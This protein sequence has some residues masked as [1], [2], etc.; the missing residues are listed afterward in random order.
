MTIFLVNSLRNSALGMALILLPISVHSQGIISE[1][2]AVSRYAQT[3]TSK[4]PPKTRSKQ[5]T[6]G[7]TSQRKPGVTEISSSQEVTFAQSENKAVFVGDVVVRDPQFVL[8]CQKLTA[9]LRGSE[10][11]EES[12]AGKGGGGL[13]RA[14][15]EGN[16][17]I[18]QDKVDADGKTTRYEGRGQRVVYETATDEVT[19]SGSPSVREGINLHI[20]TDPSTVMKITT[21]EM[22]TSGPSKTIIAPSKDD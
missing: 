4:V 8:T 16:V 19:L 9:Y 12:Q 10:V 5:S 2:A 11:S 21:S 1:T 3:D 22:I 6:F 15:A 17:V 18:I 13:E 14:I 20:A 7:D